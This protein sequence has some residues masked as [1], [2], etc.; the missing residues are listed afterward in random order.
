MPEDS[1]EHIH[2]EDLNNN[3]Y[4][5]QVPVKEFIDSKLLEQEKTFEI[6]MELFPD[7]DGGIM[8]F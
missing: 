3:G 1:I 8:I 4:S 2:F 5:V 7:L 6:E